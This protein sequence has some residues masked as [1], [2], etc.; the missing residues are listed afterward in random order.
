MRSI[1]LA[2]IATA[3]LANVAIAGDVALIIG[4]AEYDPLPDVESLGDIDDLAD[5]FGQEGI[6]VFAMSDT[7][8][9][10]LRNVTDRFTSA[11]TGIEDGTVL[12]LLS[13]QFVTSGQESWLLPVDTPEAPALSALPREAL[14]LSTVMSVLA[15][16]PG[17]A[18]LA[19]ASATSE[20]T[21][22]APFLDWGHGSMTAPQGVTVIAGSPAALGDFAADVLARPDA[23][24]LDHARD[25]GGL[26]VSGY[27]PD[28]F[29]LITDI[30]SAANRPPRERPA[31]NPGARDASAETENAFWEQTRAADTVPAYERYLDQYPDGANAE[32]ARSAIE[33]I[34][35]DPNRRERLAEEALDLA[36]EER[37]EI[38]RDLTLLEFD[39][40]GIDGIFGPGT[41]AA[42]A[43]WQA[44]NGAE[45]SGY[46]N[47]DQITR[48]DGQAERRAAELERE[49]EARRLEQERT[50]NAFWDETGAAGDEAGYRAYLKRFPEGLHSETARA[51]LDAIEAAKI[52]QANKEERGAWD[53]AREADDAAAYR[54]YLDRYPEGSF[55]DEA[56]ARLD[57]LTREAADEP[58]RAQAQADEDA[59][60]LAPLS[61]RLIEQR[62]AQLDLDPG[63]ADGTFDDDTR[64]ALRRYQETRNLPATGYVNQPTIVRLLAD[65]FGG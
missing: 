44:R 59:L 17:K 4:N 21:L 62:L 25:A 54:D 19:I 48:L 57:E 12:V 11:A 56:Q 35:T 50:D 46:L 31:D 16:H 30:G 64:K 14:P 1:L 45:P 18:V 9:I 39:P 58:Q 15:A 43:E 60:N 2:S 24:V 37:R 32:A 13:G 41:R 22:T 53:R 65:A 34:R 28:G 10:E 51:E 61:R 36:L 6:E 49:A 55:T 26:S 33:E 38:Q 23:M 29:T 63:P 47:R 27:A 52:E 20:E 3:S 42:V 40:R 7:S 5:T 8:G